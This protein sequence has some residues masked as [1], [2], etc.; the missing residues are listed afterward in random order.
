MISKYL[1][2]FQSGNTNSPYSCRSSK[3]RMN[4]RFCIQIFFLNPAFTIE[5]HILLKC[6]IHIY[7]DLKQ[8]LSAVKCKILSTAHWPMAVAPLS[9]TE[10]FELKTNQQTNKA[11]VIVLLQYSAASL[12]YSE[13]AI[14]LQL[15]YSCSLK[16]HRALCLWRKSPN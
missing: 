7:I 14:F 1:R 4:I 8:I 13:H 16:T 11:H 6:V 5:A 3:W 12:S 2:F 10:M 9:Y 15:T